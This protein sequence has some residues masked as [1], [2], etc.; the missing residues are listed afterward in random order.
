MTTSA[1][2]I[3]KRSPKSLEQIARKRGPI[4]RFCSEVMGLVRSDARLY[5]WLKLRGKNFADYYAQRMD[6][7]AAENPEGATGQPETKQFQLDYLIS[8][9]MSPDHALLDYGCGAGS[10]AVKFVGYLD[11]SNY[12]GADISQ[13]CLQVASRRME[14]HDLAG[15]RPEFVHLPSGQLQALS[16][17]TF[18]F[19]WA[20]SVLTHMPP[21]SVKDL[22]SGLLD[23]MHP[24]T[25]LLMTY[26]YTEGEPIHYRYKD[27]YFN[28][29]FFL[30]LQDELPIDVEILEDWHH[31]A[32]EIDRLV[33][34]SKQAASASK[35]A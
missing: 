33:C 5:W 22:V 25:K 19:V 30:S 12:V 21:D 9:G 18:D 14:E 27:W 11:D 2:T 15:K 35:A 29:Q 32:S 3:S 20:Q 16:G 28:D 6:R 8:R 10:A 34:V 7:I 17:R 26:A 23:V 1:P 13:E 4:S 24:D 31:P